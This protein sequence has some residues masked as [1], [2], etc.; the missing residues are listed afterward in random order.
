[1]GNIVQIVATPIA[2]A[3]EHLYKAFRDPNIAIFASAMLIGA[4][5]IFYIFFRF[6]RML[7]YYRTL[8]RITK[9]VL[10]ADTKERFC[11]EY[12]AVDESFKADRRLSHAWVEFEET[13]V[14]PEG[15]EPRV[16]RNTVRPADYLNVTAAVESGLPLQF[17]Q[18]L[19]NY[20]VGIGLLLTFFGLVAA[21]HF[22]SAG[23]AENASVNDAQKALR[24][25]LEVAS[26]KFLTSISG[27]L[28]S[29][30]LSVLI[31]KDIHRLQVAFESL[32]KSLE[33][34]LDFV[35]P[36]SV[37]LHQLREQRK[38]TNQLERFNTDFA[39]QLADAIEKKLNS[40]LG[41]ALTTALEPLTKRLEGMSS[42]IGSANEDALKK[43]LSDFTG[44]LNQSTGKEMETLAGELKN[45][46]QT[47]QQASSGVNHSGAEFGQRLESAA[48]KLEGM[49]SDSAA[50][51]RDGLA[52]SVSRMQ[53]AL[54]ASAEAMKQS[55][56][57]TSA[58][59][60]D[61]VGRAGGALAGQVN[62]AASQL[63]SSLG[64]A[65]KALG[66]LE[67]LLHTLTG[68]MDSQT[69]GFNGSMDSMRDLIRQMDVSATKLKDAAIPVASTAENLGRA[70]I[71]TD[72]A[73]KAISDTHQRISSL[74]LNL[75]EAISA[76][77]K[78]WEEYRARFE[79]VDLSLAN[80]VKEMLSGTERF[81]EEVTHFV[82]EL[83]K[84][85]SSSLNSIA[86][87]IEQF[88]DAAESLDE[89]IGKA[90]KA[91]E[92]RYST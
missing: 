88:S 50:A 7:P 1:M 23:L 44:S 67:R 87:G 35:T 28:S 75:D 80:T 34:R 77:T 62:S 90:T 76:N 72:I 69:S 92:S 51:M 64:P 47:L 86:G 26:F 8:R 22:A 30:F 20:F 83:D 27:I 37:A 4:A 57:Q 56:L 91:Q 5:V 42:S 73:N 40:T 61:A 10:I 12:P 78:V 82:T 41:A 74:V 58:G 18:A 85:L 11:A 79:Q 16:I 29:L 66:G 9:T 36:E 14:K 32:C 54:E 21:L 52:E 60:T 45:I 6:V 49:L 31:K 19:P 43:M 84:H 70:A 38:Q 33:S 81:R 3:L 48:A 2:S 46:Q 68:R 71:S 15:D 65:V 59:A 17:Y 39:I 25:L 53:M 55:A 24:S 63:E 13:L 89:T